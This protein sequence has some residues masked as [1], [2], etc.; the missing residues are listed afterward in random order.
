MDLL[1]VEL[2]THADVAEKLDS[3]IF[4]RLEELGYVLSA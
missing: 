3:I 1:R 4:A 2:R